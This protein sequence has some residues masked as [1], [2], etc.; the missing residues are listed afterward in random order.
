MGWAV[1][2][3]LD[4]SVAAYCRQHHLLSSG[5][6]VVA[7]SGG[8]DSLTLLHILLQLQNDFNISL[9]IATLD[10]GIRGDAGAADVLFVQDIAAKWG[11]PVTAEPLRKLPEC[12]DTSF[13]LRSH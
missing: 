3:T 7:V 9:H 4:R 12:C 10:H 6:I 13:C 5:Q 11:L 2:V 1:A 8:A